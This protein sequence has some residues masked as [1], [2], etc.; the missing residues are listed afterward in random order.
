LIIIG[1]IQ[2][3]VPPSSSQQNAGLF[4]RMDPVTGEFK[5]KYKVLDKFGHPYV[6]GNHFTDLAEDE[7]GNV[8][9]AGQVNN[10]VFGTKQATGWMVK[11]GIVPCEDMHCMG[12]TLSGHTH[13]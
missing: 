13:I 12:D 10:F 7:E 6:Y 5:H 2:M 3:E 1:K 4:I 11:L 9:L 8:Y